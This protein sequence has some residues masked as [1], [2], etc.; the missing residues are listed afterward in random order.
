MSCIVA[1][2]QQRHAQILDTWEICE[3]IS[4]YDFK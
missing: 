2:D 1:W 4:V 3:I